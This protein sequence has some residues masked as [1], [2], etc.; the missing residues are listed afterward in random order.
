M[1]TPQDPLDDLVMPFSVVFKPRSTN[2]DYMDLYRGEA[3]ANPLRAALPESSLMIY[4]RWDGVVRARLF[5]NPGGNGRRQTLAVLN[6][7]PTGHTT[8]AP[9]NV[10]MFGPDG[11]LSADAS[12]MSQEEV[13]NATL[14]VNVIPMPYSQP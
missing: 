1:T 9:I 5:F 14:L 6:G 7:S 4:G 8:L 3:A 10:A 2:F 12:S 13:E 11:Y